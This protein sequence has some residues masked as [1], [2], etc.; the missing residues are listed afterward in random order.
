M[1]KLR[2]A[3]SKNFLLLTTLIF[4]PTLGLTLREKYPIDFFE[5]MSYSKYFNAQQARLDPAWQFV[6]HLYDQGMDAQIDVS[7]EPKIPKK[8]HLI[9][10]GSTPPER[11]YLLEKQLREFH[12]GFEIKLWTDYDAAL[13]PMIN[14]EAYDSATNFGEKS[15]ILRYEILDREGGVYLD[16]DF[17]IAQP[18]TEIFYAA[19]FFGGLGYNPHTIELYNGFIGSEPGHPII[20]LCIS[21]LG[22][23]RSRHDPDAI[24][25]R[26]G[27]YHFTRCFLKG[28]MNAASGIAIPFPVTFF[29]PWPN[30]AIYQ[31]K[32]APAWL[33]PTSIAM[34][35][36]ARSWI[37]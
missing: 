3:M 34:H 33:Q 35:L 27:P 12:P 9:W 11:Y 2:P 22:K 5:S 6:A 32:P 21:Q 31:D 1:M 24:I 4:F 26:T 16:G 7:L 18:L 20:K 8:F 13:I 30:Y 19:N 15:D 23:D 37:N 28:A 36:W 25:D 17:L 14:R 29:Y 10:L